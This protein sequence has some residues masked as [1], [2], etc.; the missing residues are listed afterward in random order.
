MSEYYKDVLEDFFQ[1]TFTVSSR[2]TS[3]KFAEESISDSFEV[4]QDQFQLFKKINV[5]VDNTSISAGGFKINFVDEINDLNQHEISRSLDAFIRLVYDDIHEESGLY[6]ITEIKNRLS[7]KTIDLIIQMGLDLDRIQNEQHNLYNRKK[8]KQERRT[9][10]KENPLGYDWGS[11]NKWEYDGESKQVELYNKNGEV[12]DRI[13]L[14][15]AIKHYVESLSGSSN[16]ST[17]DLSNLLEE[18]EKSYSFLKL[19]NQEGMDFETAKRMLNLSNNEIK[20]LIK[21]LIELKFLQ[22][23]SNDEIEITESGKEFIQNQ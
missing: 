7:R 6:F 5:T 22:F 16:L 1:S 10:K 21:E 3:L 20:M 23:V 2:R 18:H 17:V 8:K 13:D 19:I 14:Q 4:L 11:V 9:N 15:H 12:L